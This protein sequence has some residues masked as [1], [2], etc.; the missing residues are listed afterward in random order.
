MSKLVILILLLHGIILLL[1]TIPF[2]FI[3]DSLYAGDEI[4]P[5][6]E[7]LF[8]LTLFPLIYTWYKPREHVTRVMIGLAI[9]GDCLFSTIMFVSNYTWVILDLRIILF[10][11]YFF[12]VIP[13]LFYVVTVKFEKIDDSPLKPQFNPELG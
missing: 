4:Y 6:T 11:L 7:F 3:F 2:R 8:I 13:L 10:L 5:N 12:P 1:L 9:V